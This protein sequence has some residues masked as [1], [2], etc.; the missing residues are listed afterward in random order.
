LADSYQKLANSF[1]GKFILRNCQIDLFKRRKDEW[2]NHQKG[3]KREK[4]EKNSKKKGDEIDA[5][6]DQAGK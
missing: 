1:H 3:L 4:K 2:V 5:L 6:F